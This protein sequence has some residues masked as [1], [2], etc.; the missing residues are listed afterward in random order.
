MLSFQQSHSRATLRSLEDSTT[1]ALII[2]LRYISCM[3][4][5]RTIHRLFVLQA[6]DKVSENIVYCIGVEKHYCGGCT[7][8]I[9]TSNN[10]G[11]AEM[12]EVA[13]QEIAQ[14]SSY[15]P[16]QNRGH[17]GWRLIFFTPSRSRLTIHHSTVLSARLSPSC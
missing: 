5:N 14:E 6:Q 16:G 17:V 4:R 12:V 10:D 13:C 8:S 3:K 11:R 2:M 9:G 7:R 15:E 1:I